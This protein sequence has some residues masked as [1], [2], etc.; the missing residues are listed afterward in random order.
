[1]KTIIS[2]DDFEI[3]Q[4]EDNKN[5]HTIHF[6]TYSES[7]IKSLIKTRIIL[8]AT[9]T[10]NYKS[11]FFKATTVKTFKQFQNECKTQQGTPKMRTHVAAKMVDTLAT[12]LN[13]LIT[14]NFQ[15]FIGYN[16][17]NILVIDDNKFIY[18]GISHLLN[19]D[20]EEDTS[21]ITYPFTQ[22]DFLLSPELS[23]INELPAYVHYK[24]A[25]F[26]L[27]SLIVYALTGDDDFFIKGII[28]DEK[29]REQY[30]N[31][32]LDNLHINGTKLYWLL[33]RSLVEEPK[34][35][36]IIFI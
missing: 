15:T 17:E 2:K 22:Y 9:S 12:Q 35:R 7:L 27:A 34:D 19:I 29:S 5:T 30:I 4:D 31:D 23:K 21:M 28:E 16:P 32:N 11:V 1:M 6:S 8:G 25:Y 26:S 24:V 33:K 14:V 20:V 13:Y 10:N 18:L 36:S 3:Q